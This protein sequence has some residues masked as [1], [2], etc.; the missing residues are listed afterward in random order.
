MS[1]LQLEIVTPEGKT[2]AGPVEGV[3]LPAWDGELGV[4][5]GH[6]AMITQIRTGHLHYFENGKAHYLAVGDGFV[7]ITGTKVSILTDQAV[8]EDAIDEKAVEEA[9]ARA[10]QALQDESLV[11]EEAEAVQS[12]IARSVAMLH[13]K[14]RSR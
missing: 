11:G 13:L 4:L 2:F 6:A 12:T 10:R 9:L 3:T 8:A 5:P 7:E 14:R 1:S